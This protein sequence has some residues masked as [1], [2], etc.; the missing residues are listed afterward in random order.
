MI[1]IKRV[2]KYLSR[3]NTDKDIN[4]YILQQHLRIARKWDKERKLLIASN[5]SKASS[6]QMRR[7]QLQYR[8]LATR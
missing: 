8:L 7:A 5:G 6:G 1:N 3:L 4:I 2:F